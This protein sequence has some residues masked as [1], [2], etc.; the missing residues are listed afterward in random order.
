M[1]I[2][3]KPIIMKNNTAK[4]PCAFNN[5]AGILTAIVA[6]LFACNLYAQDIHFSQINNTTLFQNPANTGAFNGDQRASIHYKNQWASVATPFTTYGLAFDMGTLKKKNQSGFL[7][8]GA[9]IYN[10]KAGDNKMQTFNGGLALAWHQYLDERNMLSGGIGASVIQN[11]IS[12][13]AMQWDSQYD[14]TGYNASLSSGETRTFQSILQFSA[15]GGLLYTYKTKDKN[16]SSNDGVSANLGV[17]VYHI[18]QPKYSFYQVAD[19][20]QYS[21]IVVHGG[22]SIGIAQSILA[23]QPSFLYQLQGSSQEIVAGFML[24]YRVQEASHFTGF[25][26]EFA[27]SAGLFY[28]VKDAMIAQFLFE[29][30]HFAVGISYDINTSALNTASNSKGGMELMLK[31]VNPNPFKSNKGHARF[32]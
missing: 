4:T 29:Y 13:S 23:V 22:M 10:D 24:R 31:F 16:I 26:S 6:M 2:I 9:V 3:H 5:R 15:G 8:I 27:L 12:P 25:K 19:E 14:G 11:S 30:N 28:R 20:K 7:G 18:N 17:G 32:L 1:L 21:K